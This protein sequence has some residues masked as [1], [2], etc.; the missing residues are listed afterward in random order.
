MSTSQ[1]QN[2]REATIR[3]V[4]FPRDTNPHGSIFGGHI[5]SLIDIAAGRQARKEAPHRYVTKKVSEV[6]FH[7]PVYVGDEVSI[8]TDTIRVG[9]TSVT[10]KVQVEAIRGVDE[11]TSH[12][13]TEAEVV[14]VAVDEHGTPIPV[15]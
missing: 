8:Y 12:E 14:M 6:I 3:T 11:V 4:M 10:I 1:S 9:T 7:A 5:M 2:H 13:V 15:H